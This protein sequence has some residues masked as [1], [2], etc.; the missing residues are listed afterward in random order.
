MKQTGASAPISSCDQSF[1]PL[2]PERADLAE[3]MMSGVP[4]AGRAMARRT[5]MDR[6]V[7]HEA[8]DNTAIRLMIMR[9]PVPI[10]SQPAGSRNEIHMVAEMLSPQPRLITISRIRSGT[11]V[12]ARVGRLVR[13]NCIVPESRTAT[14]K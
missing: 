11:V 8:A 2:A 13:R 1:H 12:A 6:V 5:S 3:L 7:N 9:P 4:A 14:T 10:S